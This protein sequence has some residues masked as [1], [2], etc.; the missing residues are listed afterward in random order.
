MGFVRDGTAE[1][2]LFWKFQ[3]G[4]IYI[5][6]AYMVEMCNQVGQAVPSWVDDVSKTS[7]LV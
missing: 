1:L 7:F 3:F 2:Y 5:I 4:N 6:L